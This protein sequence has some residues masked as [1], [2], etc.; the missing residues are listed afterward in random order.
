L[1]T[2]VDG[3]VGLALPYEMR[4]ARTFSKIPMVTVGTS[5]PGI[6]GVHVDDALVGYLAT[7]HLVELG[8]TR[9]AFLGRDPRDIFGFRVADDRYDGYVRALREAGLKPDQHLV[10]TTGFEVEGGE[11]G[12]TELLTR[13]DHL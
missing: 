9:I 5:T 10:L 7:R 3:V 11:M 13:A 6:P 2:R 12:M 1:H 8:H 4:V